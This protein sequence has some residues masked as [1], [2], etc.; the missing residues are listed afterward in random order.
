MTEIRTIRAE[1]ADAFLELLCGVFQLDLSRARNVFFSE[2]MYDLDRKWALYEEGEMRSILTTTPLLFGFG[3]AFGVAGVATVKK[4]QKQGYAQRLLETVLER[5]NDA[6][7]PGCLLFAQNETVYKRAGFETIDT[8]VK[9]DILADVPASSPDVLGQDEVRKLYGKW[10]ERDPCRLRRDDRRWKYWR[11]ILRTCEEAPGGYVCVEP[12][13]CREA[14]VAPGLESW[15]VMPG[16]H[17]TGLE[18]MTKSMGVPVENQ[19]HEL[20]VMAYRFSGRP[21]MFMTDQF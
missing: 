13:L 10:S 16:S 20:H 11:W 2:P 9:A 6:G 5:S 4:F 14:I 1:E 15:P 17:W 3:R 19:R 12:N 21:Q 7:E 18:S 8:V